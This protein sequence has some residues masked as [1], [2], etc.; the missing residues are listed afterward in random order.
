M[1]YNTPSRQTPAR[2]II[3]VD[4]SIYTRQLQNKIVHDASWLISN[5]QQEIALIYTHI[6]PILSV[7]IIGYG[8]R[9]NESV[10]LIASGMIDEM[11]PIN[12]AR[13]TKK[14]DTEDGGVQEIVFD[15]PHYIT[16]TSTWI[17]TELDAFLMAEELCKRFKSHDN[18]HGC[19]PIIVN[20]TTGKCP[21]ND[22]QR[23]IQTALSIR[24]LEF[25]DGNPIIIN[26][27]YGDADIRSFS[28][29][30]LEPKYIFDSSTI[31][32]SNNYSNHFYFPENLENEID[33][34]LK[35]YTV[36]TKVEHSYAIIFACY[37]GFEGDSGRVPSIT[38]R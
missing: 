1:Y 6:K 23:L 25:Y 4:Q 31:I 10:Y 14:I 38:V 36:T 34:K 22:Q 37:N 3:L 5:I 18:E 26:Q 2:L 16:A 28:T 35:S 21:K 13:E 11:T 20:F 17:P 7:E 12:I 33:I 24:T 29:E 19:V 30:K 32:E 27:L 9:V 15:F 8:G